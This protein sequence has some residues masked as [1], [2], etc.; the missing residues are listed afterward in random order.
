M[1]EIEL[2]PQCNTP[3]QF[4]DNHVWLAGGIIV[5]SNNRSHRMVLMESDNLDPLYEGIVDI[6]GVPIER[7]IIETKRRATREYIS[8]LIPE[9][10]KELILKKEMSV[11]PMIEALNVTSNIMGY[12]RTSLVAYRYEQDDEDFVTERIENPYSVPLWCGDLTGSTEAVTQ[13]DNTV[14]Y[15]KLSQNTIEVTSRPSEHSPELKERLQPKEYAFTEGGIELERCSVCGGPAALSN[16]VW[17]PESGVITSKET[18]R[19][20][21]MLGPHY[22]E[23]IFDELEKELGETIPRVVVEA[24]RRFVKTGFYRVKELE[25]KEA[26]R[27]MLALRGLGDLQEITLTGGGL[28]VVIRNAALHLML[29]G[30]LQGYYET[31]TGSESEVDFEM[32]DDGTLE[33]NI[34][35]KGP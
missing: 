4:V 21:A 17:R 25:D 34:T 12:G 19:R 2:C 14:T 30:L 7:I 35:A 20:V 29:A 6:I 22:Q 9:E 24:Q 3:K 13:L 32:G 5:Q 23:A 15:R 10:V 33:L 27:S 18:G 11:E 28:K 8:R 31:T 26:F 16:F 1:S